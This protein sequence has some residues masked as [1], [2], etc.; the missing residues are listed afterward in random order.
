MAEALVPGGVHPPFGRYSH[1]IAV[2]AGARLLVTS[3]QLRIAA[4]GTVP[5][6]VEDQAVL[7]FEAIGRILAE[8]GMDFGHIV[9]LNAFVTRR[10]D[11]PGLHG[12]AGPL[13]AGALA[14]IDPR[15]RHG[16]HAAGVQGRGGSHRRE[17]AMMAEA[18]RGGV[19]WPR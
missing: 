5:E 16:L 1:G 15:D 9:R 3:G 18:W 12:R 11:F 10:E 19:R 13:C 6:G 4:D 14:G 8:G 17:D 7:C 2:P